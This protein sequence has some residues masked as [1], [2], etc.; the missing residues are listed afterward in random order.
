MNINPSNPS[1]LKRE[2]LNLKQDLYDGDTGGTVEIN[3]TLNRNA[4]SIGLGLNN[5]E[6]DPEEFPGVIYHQHNPDVTC[7]VFEN[8]ITVVDAR[9]ADMAKEAVQTTLERL[10][11]LELYEENI[12]AEGEITI[13]DTSLE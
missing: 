7:I 4:V 6:Y 10:K 5:I 12:P 8:R 13:S 2:L 9:N 3:T 11:K 1:E